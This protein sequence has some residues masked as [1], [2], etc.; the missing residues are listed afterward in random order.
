M[1]DKFLFMMEGGFTK[2]FHTVPTV[3][4]HTVGHHS[5]GVACLCYLLSNCEPSAKLLMAALSHDMAEQWM[6]DIPSPTKRALPTLKVML[7]IHEH[8]MLSKNGLDINLTVEEQDI[9]KMADILD[10]LWNCCVERRLGNQ[11]IV[12]PYENFRAYAIQIMPAKECPALE[13]FNIID[14]LWRKS[15]GR[16]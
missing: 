1:Q 12:V 11:A 16:S 6:G 7:D 3:R 15:N 5:F 2:R 10:G 9:L 13:I 14:N 4:E 8:E